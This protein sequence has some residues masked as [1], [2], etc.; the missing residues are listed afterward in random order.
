M[1]NTIPRGADRIVETACEITTD[2]S[3]GQWLRLG[4]AIR[5]PTDLFQ[6]DYGSHHAPGQD[7]TFAANPTRLYPW[8][9]P[10][11]TFVHD[12]A[13]LS[14]SINIAIN[15][16]YASVFVCRRARFPTRASGIS[17]AQ[18]R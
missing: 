1:A 8:P 18:R 13:P 9:R 17:L 4:A 10:I 3:T 2:S 14:E 5:P 11:N 16:L 6:C 15:A 7:G 12:V